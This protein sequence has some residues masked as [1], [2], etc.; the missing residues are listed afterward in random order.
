VAARLLAQR[1][2]L[3]APAVLARRSLYTRF[4]RFDESL[5][6]LNDWLM[7]IRA[8]S[9]GDV[10]VCPRVL[11]NYRVHAGNLS[12]DS[13]RANR[14]GEEMLRFVEIVQAEWRDEPFPGARQ[15]IAAGGTSEILADAG[16]RAERGDTAG[17]LVQVRR[18]RTIA[19][20]L[21]QQMLVTL[22]EE[23]IRL[24]DLPVLRLARRPAARI[25]RQLWN[26]LRPAA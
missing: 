26:L 11:A 5:L 23:A 19:P 9:T 6:L 25:G 22:A 15:A 8:A 2:W 24:T 18:A 14:W 1:N 12:A 4:P 13:T 17:A 16:L 20:T 10:E 3:R 21:K 7:W